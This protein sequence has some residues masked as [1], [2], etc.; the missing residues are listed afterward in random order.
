MGAAEHDE[1]AWSDEKP[2]FTNTLDYDYYIARYPVS[3]AQYRHFISNGGY[4]KK[5]YWTEAIADDRWKP[6][7]VKIWDEWE[8]TP[9]DYGFPYN[10]DNHP[11]VGVSWY[12]AMAFCRWL[13]EYLKTSN[14][15]LDL[16]KKLLNED[17][18]ITLPSEA[19]WEK[20][21]RGVDDQRIYPWGADLDTDKVNYD[22][23]K[24]GTSSALGCF[25]RG[26]SPLK[27][28]EMV[29]NVSE[30]CR[31]I[32]QEDYE[33]YH[34]ELNA[35][36]EETTRVFRG[37]AFGYVRRFVRCSC[38]RGNHPDY[39]GYDLGFRVCV[40]PHFSEL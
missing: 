22:E 31:T 20:A 15:T 34:N 3:N 33:N 37:G 26:Q 29:D 8:N 35:S 18:H 9:E 5:E 13:T 32:W 19:E 38:R 21:A 39:R 28:E 16:I 4:Q 14:K 30:W 1:E 23:T 17:H 27:C 11:V 12:E 10:L 36:E 2:G 24:I 6:G 25:P 7:Q 40:C